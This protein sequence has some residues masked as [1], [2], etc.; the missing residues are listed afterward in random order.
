MTT[1][2]RVKPAEGRLVRDPDTYQALPA[3][4][5]PVEMNSYW[6]RKL[7]AGDVVIDPPESPAVKD[8]G[9]KP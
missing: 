2:V 6:Q 9:E 1:R 7:L 5:A 3:D 4:G 8:K